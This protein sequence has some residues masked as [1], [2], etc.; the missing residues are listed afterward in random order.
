MMLIIASHFTHNNNKAN[1]KT[2]MPISRFVAWW[3]LKGQGFGKG[4]K[5][6][7]ATKKGMATK[8]TQG[9]PNTMEVIFAW[10]EALVINMAAQVKSIALHLG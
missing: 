7:G 3:F 1:H 2:P 5:G 8:P 10:L 9:Q 4:Q 6:K